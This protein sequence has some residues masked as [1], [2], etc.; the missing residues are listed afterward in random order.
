[1]LAELQSLCVSR[2]TNSWWRLSLARI[3]KSGA[4]AQPQGLLQTTGPEFEPQGVR[5]L[6]TLV[7]LADVP[8]ELYEKREVR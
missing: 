5:F 6:A 7:K 2:Q 4:S 1:M 3:G 8:C